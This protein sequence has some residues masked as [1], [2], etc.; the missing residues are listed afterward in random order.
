MII[1]L[2]LFFESLPV[3]VP[4]TPSTWYSS[5]SLPRNGACWYSVS[6]ELPVS[7]TLPVSGVTQWSA[8]PITLSTGWPSVTY[9]Y[10]L[11]AKLR[12]PHQ[13]RNNDSLLRTIFWIPPMSLQATSARFALFTAIFFKIT[14]IWG[15]VYLL[16]EKYIGNLF[17]SDHNIYNSLPRGTRSKNLLLGVPHFLYHQVPVTVAG[18]RLNKSIVW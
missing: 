14:F 16:M 13:V 5:S 8:T 6:S 1:Y 11:I 4:G 15:N 2:G 18:Q 12:L 7:V 9:E 3:P 17:P 10:L